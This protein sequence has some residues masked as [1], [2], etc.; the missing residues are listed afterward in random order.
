M[1]IVA[2]TVVLLPQLAIYYQATGRLFVS[3][4]GDLGFHFAS[5]QLW[6]VLFSVQKGLFFWSPR[7]ARVP[8]PAVV[9]W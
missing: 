5:P 8:S 4:Y 6:G 7:S 3:S 1:A 2:A 9:A